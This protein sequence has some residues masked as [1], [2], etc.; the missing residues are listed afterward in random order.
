L[1]RAVDVGAHTRRAVRVFLWVG[2]R[3]TVW[4]GDRAMA[5]KGEWL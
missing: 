1:S 5:K 4:F 3:A 2:E